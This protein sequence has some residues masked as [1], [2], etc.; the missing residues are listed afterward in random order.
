MRLVLAPFSCPS[1]TVEITSNH[2]DLLLYHGGTDRDE[3]V[4]RGAALCGIAIAE[5]Q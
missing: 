2:V 4:Q 5:V 3:N 1:C